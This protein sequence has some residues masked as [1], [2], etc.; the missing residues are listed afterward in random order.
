MLGLTERFNKKLTI[1]D[2]MIIRKES[3]GNIDST[4][5][6]KTLPYLILQ[7][8]M[9]FDARSRASLYKGKIQSGSLQKDKLHPLDNLI[10]LLHCCNNFLIQDLLTRLSTCQL[11]IPFLLPNP[12]DES[13][14]Y[15]LWGMREIIREWK[16]TNSKVS[17]ECRI[18]DYPAPIVSFYKI[19]KLKRSKSK[20]INEVIGKSYANFFFNWDCEG[21]TAERL[22]VDGMA[23]MCCYLPSEKDSFYSDIIIF[24]N[25]RG[26]ARKHLKQSIFMQKI[27][28]MSFVLL[29]ENDLDDE[30][31]ELLQRLKESPGGVIVM[32][33]DLMK[34]EKPKNKKLYQE[35][36]G[37]CV[38]NLKERNSIEIKTDLREKI[39]EK[40]C[41]CLQTH[42]KKLSECVEIAQS[43]EI[44]IDEDGE[45]STNGKKLAEEVMQQITSHCAHEDM[46][47]MLPLQGPDLWHKWA[48]LDKQSYRQLKKD[49][50]SEKR[51]VRQNQLVFIKNSSPVMDAFLSHLLNHTGNLRLYFLHWLKMLLDD[52]AVC[53]IAD[54]LQKA[55]AETPSE[56][57]TRKLKPQKNQLS[58]ASLGLEHFFR[59]M[60][61]MYE[62]V[63]DIQLKNVPQ[64]LKDLKDKV[65]SYPQ[66]IA[67]LMSEGY[68][69]ELMDGYAAHVPITWVKA[70]ISKLEEQHPHRRR[71]FVISVLGIQST[72][73]STLL[74]TTFGLRFRV[75]PGRCTRGAYFQLL[76]FDSDMHKQTDCDHILIIDTEGL[77]APEL[78]YEEQQKHDNELATL[79]IGLADLTIINIYGETPGGDMTDILQ[80]AVHAF[81]RMK[82]I[83]MQLSCYYVHQNVPAVTA[84]S[85][86]KGG[87]QTFQDRL[88]EMTKITAKVE[89]CERSYRRF[90]DVIQFDSEKN[91]IFF[92][93]LW[94]GDPPMAPVNPGY[95]AKACKIKETVMNI[96]QD[97]YNGCNFTDFQ[98]RIQTL[99]NAVLQENYV[100][101][102]KN[103]L[104][105]T[106]YNEL[107]TKYSQW[108]WDL[109][110]KMLECQNKARNQINSSNILEIDDVLKSCLLETEEDMKSIYLKLNQ[111]LP[112]FFEKSERSITLSQ[113]RKSTEVKLKNLY[114]DHK[115]EAKR[116]CCMLCHNRKSQTEIDKIK[117]TYRQQFKDYCNTLASDAKMHAL[118]CEEVFNN[119]WEEWIKEISQNAKTVAY[120]T[121][122][123]IELK[124]IEILN[125]KYRTHA[126]LPVL[127]SLKANPLSESDTL[128]KPL[129][130]SG[131][132]ELDI[133]TLHL[134]S[135]TNKHVNEDFFFARNQTC[136]FFHQVEE[137]ME[138]ILKTFQDFSKTLVDVN[139]LAELQKAIET[140]NNRSNNFI[141]TPRYQIDIAII[142]S[143]YAYQQFTAKIKELLLENDPVEAMNTL[144]P[145]YFR[146]F[147]T[148]FSETFDDKSAVLNFCNILKKSIEKALIEKL[149]I[150]IVTHMKLQ[151]IFTGKKCFKV[152]VMK[153]LA[154]KNNFE[155]YKVYFENI[156]TSLK[157]WLK[158]Y[159]KQHCELEL[160]TRNGNTT[161]FVL[162]EENLNIITAG[163]KKV[164]K[165]IS[166]FTENTDAALRNLNAQKSSSQHSDVKEW[167]ENFHKDAKKIV[168]VDLE[169]IIEMIGINS[170]HNL[171]F[172][173]EQLVVCLED[174]SK[175]ILS[176]FHKTEATIEKLTESANSPH[177]ILYNSLIGCKEQCPFCKEQ[178]ELTDKNHLD[179][180]IDHYTEIHRPSCLG[181]CTYQKDK[182]LAFDTC[183]TNIKSTASFQ[184][185]DTGNEPCPF[186]KYR[187][188]Y[189]YWNISTKNSKTEPKYWERFIAKYNAELVAW[190]EAG[191]SPVDDLGWENITEEV[192]IDNLSK[193][194]MT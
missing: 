35:L 189:P 41:L 36:D 151:S 167:L 2:A 173:T 101:S 139:L 156:S 122:E 103:I 133:T 24:T 153:D 6:P 67:D 190:N 183:N 176:E 13:I 95:T 171:A 34:D 73:K 75:S 20:I 105:V 60:G 91:V 193:E 134:E 129:S 138:R 65:S 163:I 115:D 141:F 172:F 120:A 90:Q 132:L 170:I 58:N 49:T 9:M 175:A 108:S 150:E 55:K 174:E 182:K 194:Y 63:M 192:A 160:E 128:E 113:W 186:K 77:H 149:Q 44:Q 68:P 154:V 180:K 191:P 56:I 88:D 86:S 50:D 177:M 18:V 155:L 48:M 168:V 136:N 142:V 131:T 157:Y 71:I 130:E 165:G 64:D 159:V 70:V 169:E 79:V 21:G 117:Q 37:T 145:I 27:S 85:K 33:D 178:C 25:L 15:L 147:K 62:V 57:V 137:R 127:Q 143:R 123:H 72:G 114:E 82:N 26:D 66:V 84:D 140:F 39:A 4:N 106:A 184:N 69:V 46:F 98:L 78:H 185:F 93:S 119:K 61:Q 124:I 107:D 135:T 10:I 51:A 47:K 52:Y 12:N 100:F 166:N 16:H 104:E 1:K 92:P 188:I 158:T 42:H 152:Q 45:E 109:Q 112:E 76:S 59:E 96:V 38:I 97:R 125:E 3:L 87:R 23:E 148:Q 144:K 40:L 32:F 11:A 146:K 121:P 14:L 19:G 81:I 80:T 74:N 22:F 181:R 126:S 99:W 8:I 5:E 83:D 89:K 30:V 43:L 111:E 110:H 53:N 54:R 94:E 29:Q 102:F 17:T 28:F 179:S 162:A 164:I 161:I 7:K 31:L 118:K 116:H 187:K